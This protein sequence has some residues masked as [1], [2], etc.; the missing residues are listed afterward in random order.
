VI[1]ALVLIA[2]A[3]SAGPK[4]F[5][6]EHDVAQPPPTHEP[7][8]EAK[9][10]ADAIVHA[11][12]IVTEESAMPADPGKV[13]VAA[14]T[15][16][17]WTAPIPWT[18]D[19]AKDRDLLRGT[20]RALAMRDHLPPD[21]VLRA[22]RA[23]TLVADDLQTFA[24]SRAGVSALFALIDGGPVVQLGIVEHRLDDG[25]WAVSAVIPGSAANTAGVRRGDLLVSIDSTPIDRGW[26]D[27]AYL[28]GAAPGTEAKLVVRRGDAE[29]T[30]ALRLTAVA[31]PGIDARTM[32]DAIGYVRIWACTHS[33]DPARDAAAQLQK[34]F[35]DFDKKRVKKLVVD[36]RG[37]A[38]GF[39]FDIASLLAD[40]DPLMFGITD[41]AEQPVART[42]LA[43]WKTKRPL[44]V[45]VDEATA[46]G[47]EMIALALR[48]HAGAMIVGR[49]TAGGL[50][51]P[52]TEKLSGDVTLSYPLSRV[53]SAKTKSVQDGNRITPDI[54]APN[55]SADDYAANRDPQLDAALAA[56]SGT[57]R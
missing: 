5:E 14:V 51:F 6:R 13:R 26:K 15:A 25:R 36:L 52:T 1:R 34:I 38:G 21:A 18:T 22:T 7:G 56:L 29:Q 30:F 24:I 8:P 20:V 11:Y 19:A 16:L 40:A 33:D 49:P 3:C 41:G 12:Q 39:P 27:F 4:P 28:L 55:P 31:V 54:A 46:S 2:V 17:G 9:A 48:D 50:T 35:T 45:I 47:A 44:A 57:S 32:P 37:N 10:A 42:K 53:G 23:M 43:A